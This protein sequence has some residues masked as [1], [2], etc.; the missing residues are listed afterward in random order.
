MEKIHLYDTRTFQPICD[1]IE[2]QAKEM[3]FGICFS[4]DGSLF[5][6]CGGGSVTLWHT[7]QPSKPLRSFRQIP[8]TLWGVTFSPDGS[9][10]LTSGHDGKLRLWHPETGEQL[11][12]LDMEGIFLDNGSFSADGNSIIASTR[13]LCESISGCSGLES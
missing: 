4:P 9:R 2:P 11:L 6:T 1:P 5:A 12:V 8:G 10:I 3:C 7:S 13:W